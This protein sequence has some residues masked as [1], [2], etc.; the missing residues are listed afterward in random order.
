MRNKIQLSPRVHTKTKTILIYTGA[1]IALTGLV[2]FLAVFLF[3][4]GRSEDAMA[5]TQTFSTIATGNWTTNNIWNTGTAPSYTSNWSPALERNVTINHNVALS[6]TNITFNGYY[7]TIAINNGATLTATVTTLTVEDHNPPGV[8]NFNVING[9]LVI[10]GNLVLTNGGTLN[11]QGAGNVIINGNL[12]MGG[13]GGFVNIAPGGNLTVTGNTTVGS[14]SKIDNNGN[15]QTNNLTVTGGSSNFSS[16]STLRVLNDFTVTGSGSFNL[17][18]GYVEVG[19]DFNNNGGSTS[20]INGYLDV[21]RNVNNSAVISNA[22]TG[23]ISWDGTWNAGG[24][25]QTPYAVNGQPPT[26]NPYNLATGTQATLALC[27]AATGDNQSTYGNSSWIGYVYD[28]INLDPTNYMG[29]LPSNFFSTINPVNFDINFGGNAD[30]STFTTQAGCAVERSTFSVRF[31]M[32]YDFGAECA[33]YYITVGA[34]DGFRLFIDGVLQPSLS[35][36]ATQSY[37][38]RAQGLTLSGVKEFVLEY[39]ENFSENRVTFNMQTSDNSVFPGTIAGTQD[40]CGGTLDPAA[41]TSTIPALSCNAFT[42][43]WQYQ[44]NCSGTWFNVPGA[45]NATYNIPANEFL[46]VRCYRRSASDNISTSYSNTLTVRV[47]QSSGDEI[48]YGTDQWI[49]H[50]YK[51]RAGFNSANYAGTITQNEQFDNSF[52]GNNCFFNTSGCPVQTED[53]SVRYKMR[54]DLPA[55]EYTFTIGGDDGVR[56]SLNGGSSWF[57]NDWSNHGYRETSNATTYNHPGGVIDF[58][59]EYYEASGGNRVSFSYLQVSLLPIELISFTAENTAKGVLLK[60]VTSTETDNDFFTLERTKDGKNYELVT[61]V[62]GAGNSKNKKEYSWVDDKA[63]TGLSYYRLKQTDFNGQFEYFPLISITRSGAAGS[64]QF[65][66]SKSWPNP[67]EDEFSM[68]FDA[69][70]SGIAEFVIVNASGEQVH[71]E[72]I[73]VDAGENTHNYNQGFKLNSGVYLIYFIKDGSRTKPVR[74]VKK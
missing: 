50:V 22:S 35:S 28:G 51:Q 3:N 34:D 29:R 61:N 73:N 68:T 14:G 58:V 8:T 1:G 72:K 16:T 53:F 66:I 43:Q 70:E 67:F 19:R 42:Y 11:I 38:T 4:I 49:G 62:D 20:T 27:Q 52:C 15:M 7:N 54:K 47:Y 65:V 71:S 36:W 33:P 13:S 40:V 64:R 32:R 21:G 23:V 46:G 63:Y 39:Y 25:S 5:N 30:A 69:P 12:T 18:S 74:I 24:G 37:T 17:E 44:E 55:G 45:N 60:W 41:F 56:L 9:T 2:A 26:S 6:A 59:L 10:N 57:L 48:S 31:R